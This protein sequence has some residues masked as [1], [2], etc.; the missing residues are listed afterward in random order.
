VVRVRL[1]RRSFGQA[2]L[3]FAAQA[4]LFVSFGQSDGRSRKRNEGAHQ[5]KFININN[6]KRKT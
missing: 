4:A 1:A 5:S 6:P 3:F 2:A